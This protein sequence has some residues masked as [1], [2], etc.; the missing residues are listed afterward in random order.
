MFHVEAVDRDVLGHP[1]ERIIDTGGT[2]L[3]AA[4]D[5]LGIV[6]TC[7]LMPTSPGRAVVLTKMGVR[8]SVRGLKVGE[9]LLREVIRHALAMGAEPLFLLTNACCEAAIHLYEKLGFRHDTDIMAH[10]GA[11]YA[12][13]NVA[14]R[15]NPPSAHP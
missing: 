10:Y 11:E 3:F 12:R 1:R 5:R 13:C 2:I 15:Y 7:A 6:G 9:F 14:M 4:S 8:E